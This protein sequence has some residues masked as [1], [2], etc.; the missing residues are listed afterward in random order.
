MS[1][2]TNIPS[3]LIFPSL[4][5]L[6]EKQYFKDLQELSDL[7]QSDQKAYTYFKNMP[8]YVISE[9]KYYIWAEN[10]PNGKPGKISGGFT[11][12]ANIIFDGFDYSG[13]NFNFY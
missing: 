13:K 10:S 9:K 7:G 4:G 5:P 8:V 6:D 12:P 2:P 3:P 1:I 11:Y